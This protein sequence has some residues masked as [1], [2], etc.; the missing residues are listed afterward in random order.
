MERGYDLQKLSYRLT[1]TTFGFLHLCTRMSDSL[2]L[3]FSIRPKDVGAFSF[4]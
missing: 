1:E 3:A 4:G 2:L